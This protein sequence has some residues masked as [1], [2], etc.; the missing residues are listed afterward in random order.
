MRYNFHLELESRIVFQVNCSMFT[1]LQFAFNDNKP[2]VTRTGYD[3]CVD[4]WHH[5]RQQL[6]VYQYCLRVQRWTR[7][8]MKVAVDV[9]KTFKKSNVGFMTTFLCKF[10]VHD[11]YNNEKIKTG[12]S[13]LDSHGQ[14]E[15]QFHWRG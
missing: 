12:R 3:N 11:A 15:E 13:R 6:I 7:K 9:V 1:S 10:H 8:K 2:C 5:Q 4:S 14:E